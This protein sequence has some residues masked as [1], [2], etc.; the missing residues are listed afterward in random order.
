MAKAKPNHY[1]NNEELL[2]ELTKHKT[3]K[4]EAELLGLD[5]PRIPNSIGAMIL[6]I[7]QRLSYSPNFINYSFREEMVGDAI[8]NC[9][10]Y[11][12]N[13]DPKFVSERGT[14]PNPFAY[15]TQIAWYAFIRRIDREKT[16]FQKKARYLQH[17]LVM[18]QSFFE[19]I[20]DHDSDEGFRNDY[21]DHLLR[22]YE[23]EIV[24][25]KPRKKRKTKEATD[26]ADKF[27]KDIV[28]GT[29]KK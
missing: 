9:I 21:M 2:A 23:A 29:D 17:S 26:E 20:S 19:S 4:R 5:P 10:M 6:K 11:L 8:E 25:P 14:K 1:V 3:A 28:G 7:C 18:D 24:E 22:Y 15:F 27:E 13:F 12:D 16:Q